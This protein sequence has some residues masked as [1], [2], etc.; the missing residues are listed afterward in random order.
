VSH[1]EQELTEAVAAL[2]QRLLAVAGYLSDDTERTLAERATAGVGPL[3]AHLADRV[4]ENPAPERLWLLGTAIAGGY[5]TLGEIAA[6]RRGLELASPLDRSAE[7]LSAVAV[8]AA[9]P[10][11]ASVRAEVVDTVVVDVDFCAR[12]THN[13]GIQRVVRNTVSH[14]DAEAATLASWSLDGTGLRR[15]T[16]GQEKL[17]REWSSDLDVAD[18]PEPAVLLIPWNTTVV[19]PEVPAHR[20]IDRL[21]SIASASG[22]RMGLIG[23]DAIPLVSADFV[24]DDESDRFAHYLTIVKHSSVISGISETTA[25]E[26]RAFNSALAAQGLAGP[27]VRTLLLPTVAPRGSTGPSTRPTPLVL[28]VGS[29]EPRKNQLGVMSAAREL[30]DEGLDFELLFVGGGGAVHVNALDAAIRRSRARGFAVSHGRGISDDA[31]AAAYRD[32]RVVV[33]PSLQEGYGLPVAEALASGTPVITSNFGS[34]AEIAA[35]GG[36]L[37]VNP[38]VDEEIA[39]ALRRVLTDDE[40]HARLV[41]ETSALSTAGWSDYAA[42]LWKQLVSGGK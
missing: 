41:A 4:A 27:E 18:E 7:C 42:A 13:T 25:S 31:L 24:S 11:N 15:L 38:R 26:F 22:N 29:I 5:P 32:A 14:W 8:T 2:H 33:F 39:T 16:P 23:Y 19:L 30:W 9:A 10:R 40:L 37:L 35:S 12:H 21:V 17:V 36:C 1:A 20:L 28:M 34:T 6:M 3:V